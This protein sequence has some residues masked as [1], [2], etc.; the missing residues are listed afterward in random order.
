MRMSR[1][2]VQVVLAVAVGGAVAGG[3]TGCAS[4]AAEHLD[5]SGL[6]VVSESRDGVVP[7]RLRDAYAAYDLLTE[8][9]PDDFGFA[10]PAIEGVTVT[11]GTTSARGREPAHSLLDGFAGGD[12]G[13]C[14]GPDLGRGAGDRTARGR[15]AGD[16]EPPRGRGPS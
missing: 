6:V 4:G 11:V 1:H 2:V 12:L 16:D 13:V 3:V 15:G 14:P 8:A 9:N 5:P 7:E 10:S